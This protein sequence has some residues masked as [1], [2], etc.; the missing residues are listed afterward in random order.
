MSQRISVSGDELRHRVKALGLTYTQAAERLGLSRDGLNKQMRG[1]RRVGRQTLIIL[2]FLE[3]D[4][5]H[6]IR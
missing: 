5:D 1:D 3:R 2:D 4:R 6:P